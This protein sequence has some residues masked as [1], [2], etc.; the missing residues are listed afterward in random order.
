MD[1]MDLMDDMDEMDEMD[2][3]KM[4]GGRNYEVENGYRQM[5]LSYRVL[6]LSSWVLG[7]SPGE[8]TS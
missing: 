2:R 7:R 6:V 8:N 3:E 4:A 1:L 5:V